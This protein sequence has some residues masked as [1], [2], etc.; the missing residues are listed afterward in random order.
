MFWQEDEYGE[1]MWITEPLGVQLSTSNIKKRF[2]LYG[3][4]KVH[5]GL[6]TPEDEDHHFDIHY[7]GSKGFGPVFRDL[8]QEKFEHLK[9]VKVAA[10]KKWLSECTVEASYT[11]RHYIVDNE[12][13][14]F[15]READDKQA[16]ISNFLNREIDYEIIRWE[17]YEQLGYEILPNRYFYE[18]EEPEPSDEI[19]KEFWELEKE[20]EEVLSEIRDL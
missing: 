2:E 12:Y 19:I 8:L 1:Q 7:E 4:L 20:A 6:E 18:Y 9:D 16:Y 13:I 11:H 3:D 10:V 14:P 17:E 5:V 15:D